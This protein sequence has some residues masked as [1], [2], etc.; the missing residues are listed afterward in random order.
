MTL[1]RCP[2]GNS[3]LAILASASILL[4]LSPVHQVALGAGEPGGPILLASVFQPTDVAANP[5]HLFVIHHLCAALGGIPV[6]GTGACPGL[7]SLY[8][9]SDHSESGILAIDGQGH[10][11]TIAVIHDPF[12]CMQRDH[13]ALSS[14]LG[15]FPAGYLYA[16][17][18]DWAGVRI[19]RM[20]P[21]GSYQTSI[22]NKIPPLGRDVHITFD[23]TGSFGHKMIISGGSWIWEVGPDGEAS[24]AS[25]VPE[26]GGRGQGVG[27]PAVAPYSFGPYGGDLIVPDPGTGSIYAISPNRTVTKI[28]AWP[29]AS[30]IL[31]VPTTRC[32]FGSSGAFLLS[33]HASDTGGSVVRYPLSDFAGLAGSALVA[34]QFHPSLVIIAVQNGTLK[35]S[36]FRQE[37]DAQ[38]LEGSSF[39]T[40]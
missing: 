29:G 5:S 23:G 11:K 35:F 16:V 27:A 36:Q 33:S 19:T 25:E 3:H 7:T 21:D 20:S 34:S 6:P 4:T 28:G 2:A 14:G 31:F 8:C 13:R 37:I 15:G 24:P 39:A 26:R 40:C 1:P 10:E 12:G 32:T 38:F 18:G 17:Q 22:P 30:E 9:N